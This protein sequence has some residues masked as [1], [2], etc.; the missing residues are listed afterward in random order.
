[1]AKRK[2]LDKLIHKNNIPEEIRLINISNIDYVTPS[3]KIY[4]DYGNNM[5]YQKVIFQNKAN[6]YSYVNIQLK[7]GKTVQRR[8]HRLVA[9][10]YIP[11]LE[12]YPVVMHINNIKSDNRVSNLKWGT[13]S[14]NTLSAFRDG[15]VVNAK[16]FADSQSHSVCQFNLQHQLV[17]IFG[18]IGQTAIATGLTKTTIAMQCKHRTKSIP[19][20]GF[21]FR[22]LN[23]YNINGFIL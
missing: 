2:L 7:N 6:K 11:N 16:G 19:R 3:G 23:E 10:A 1:M 22:Y 21:Y 8:V 20:S 13:V 5:F 18:S 9:S 12:N 14:E 17:D 15:L 4:T